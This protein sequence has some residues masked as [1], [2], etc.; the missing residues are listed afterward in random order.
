MKFLGYK[1]A[2]RRPHLIIG[3]KM[4]PDSLR[5]NG[6]I[7]PDIE[8]WVKNHDANL[9]YDPQ[10]F[11]L[12]TGTLLIQFYDRRQ[13]RSIWQGYATTTYGKVDFNNQRQ[14]KNAV[15]SILD[16]YRFW[17]EGFEEGT[18]TPVDTEMP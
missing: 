7:Q 8:T 12:N 10:K 5:F 1:R 13:N 14:M 2:E 18:Q 11:N 3:Y 17:A 16:K 9:N 15:F 4:F 6:Y